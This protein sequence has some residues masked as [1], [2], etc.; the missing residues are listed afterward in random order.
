MQEGV[1]IY[2]ISFKEMLMKSERLLIKIVNKVFGK[3]FPIDSE[4]KFLN[5]TTIGEDGS[6]LEKD[7]YFEICGER[8]HIEAQSYWDDMMFRLFEYAVSTDEGYE[9]IDSTHAVYHM[10]KQAVVF[11]K[12][13]NK[14]NDKLFIRL[15][16][17][18]EQEV[19]YS[20]HAIRALGYYP[21][22]LVENDMEILLPFQI[23]RLYNKVGSYDGYSEE[24]KDKFWN[25]YKEICNS[26]VVTLKSLLD[27]GTITNDD[28]QRM[29]EITKSLDEYVYGLL[30]DKSTRGA[31]SMLQEKVMLWG[32]RIRAEAK[33]EAKAE[34]KNELAEMM[35]NDEK[36]I[37]EIERYTGL[38]AAALKQIAKSLGKTLV[39]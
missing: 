37:D 32:D 28:Y 25:D 8:F 15:I 16:L 10:P 35:I 36:P 7:V 9:K 29:I 24:E 5:A 20:V 6:V 3:H 21:E 34:E 30:A 31:D 1:K 39:I 26:V 11:L 23:I 33:A 19:E 22:E 27:E 14:A 13:T 2:D 18:D 4:I 38:N 17:P 12:D